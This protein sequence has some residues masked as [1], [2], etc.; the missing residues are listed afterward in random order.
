MARKDIPAYITEN[1]IFATRLKTVMGV[2]GINQ[3]QLS[4]KIQREQGK[5]LQRQT[6]SQYLSGQ[7]KPD[8]ERLTLLC[9]ALDVS[10]DYLLGI[11]DI[12]ARDTNLQ[13]VCE[14]TGLSTEAV[15]NLKEIMRNPLF[16][17]TLKKWCDWF[18]AS[19]YFKQFGVCLS[20]YEAGS[21]DS[22]NARKPG[23]Y[24]SEII[25]DTGVNSP[26]NRR[27][28]ARNDLLELLFS[29]TREIDEKAQ[30]ESSNGKH[31]TD[32]D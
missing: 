24:S 18:I 28:A 22:K 26:D 8:T 27:K 23:I 21:Y 10:A 32:G 11:S 13:A 16:H 20:E 19:E 15:Q 7:S 17:P 29:I 6:I 1:D 2:R 5:V 25:I 30:E 31:K 4:A 12:Q 9:N 14:Y 3:T